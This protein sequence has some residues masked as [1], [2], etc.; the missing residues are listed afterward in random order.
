MEVYLELMGTI[1]ELPLLDRPRQKA[2]RYGLSTLSDTELLALLISSGYQG[3]NALM[4][5]STLINQYNGLMNLS[6]AQV[7]ELCKVKGI[8][9]AK[10]MNIAAIFEIHHRLLNKQNEIVQVKVTTDYLYNKYKEQMLRSHQEN[11]VLIILNKT[12]KIIF[13]KLLYIGTEHNVIFS[14]KDIWR[15]LFN[16]DGKFFYLI[17]SHPTGEANP[18]D[19]DI[20]FSEELFLESRRI[21]SP[22]IDHLIIGT[23]GYYSFQKLEKIKN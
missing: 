12:K 7:F 19:K 22:M 8:K 23:D 9:E 18:S 5:A 21:N 14:Y 15:E 11:L 13:E 1:E 20:M 10:A 4:V 6:K 17:H 2:L 16:H 3:N